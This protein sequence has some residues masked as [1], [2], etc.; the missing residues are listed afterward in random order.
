MWGYADNSSSARILGLFGIFWLLLA[1]VMF[2]QQLPFVLVP[3]GPAN[4]RQIF[5]DH[6]GRL[7]VASFTD[8]ACFDGSRFYSM[9]D[10]GFQAIDVS[11]IAEDSDGA[12]WIGAGNGVYRFMRVK[13]NE[14][15][16]ALLEQLPL[17]LAPF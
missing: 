6:L 2:G 14:L 5:Q 9:R 17:L 1:N 15:C 16:R 11:A 3:G 12:I 7:W 13:S 8:L 10:F 4:I